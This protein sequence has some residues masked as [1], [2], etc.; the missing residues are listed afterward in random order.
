MKLQC[1]QCGSDV[2][3]TTAVCP[4][5]GH[6]F[7]E[8]GGSRPRTLRRSSAST[9]SSDGGGGAKK[10]CLGRAILINLLIVA[11]IMG[12]IVWTTAPNIID[13]EQPAWS[14][15]GRTLA[16]VRN[17]EIYLADRDGDNETF[18]TMGQHPD[19]SPDGQLLAFN[20]TEDGDNDIY[21]IRPD[22]SERAALTNDDFENS[23]P[24]WLP[25]SRSLLYAR[26]TGSGEILQ[27]SIRG[28]ESLPVSRGKPPLDVSP[29]GLMLAC[30]ENGILVIECLN[31]DEDFTA[32]SL[33]TE[34]EWELRFRFRFP[35]DSHPSWGPDS[36]SFVYVND[37][38]IYFNNSYDHDGLTFFEQPLGIFFD[39]ADGTAPIIQRDLTTITYV[40]EGFLGIFSGIYHIEED[41]WG[42]YN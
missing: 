18:L 31:E 3:E 30:D 28:G 11:I 9:P 5:C 4:D 20:D 35:N 36:E 25:D 14:P 13:A 10:S 16:Y 22:G 7:V 41:D 37:G 15:D 27:I 39:V 19:W 21:I 26:E 24:R 29:D 1:P 2:S 34:H 12:I 17:S 42:W 6:N 8:I 40:G 33:D 32:W 23:W 38:T